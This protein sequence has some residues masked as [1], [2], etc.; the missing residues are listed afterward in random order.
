M[1]KPLV[2]VGIPVFNARA[3][4]K[5]A[6]RSVMCQSF[7]DWELLIVDDGS[8]DGVWDLLSGL[9]DPRIHCFRHARN[10]GL[11]ATLNEIA[12]AARGEFVARMDADD[13]MHPARLEAQLAAF[14]Q[15]PELSFLWSA[16]YVIG[17][18][19]ELAGRFPA[20]PG[21]LSEHVLLRRNPV[22]HPAVMARTTWMR[23][24][25]YDAGY[26]RA[27][28][29][30]LWIRTAG[31]A[32]SRCLPRP[33]LFYRLPAHPHS[34]AYRAS[35]RTDRKIIRRHGP[36]L[37]GRAHTAALVARSYLKQWCYA[38]ACACGFEPRL[39]RRR[40]LPLSQ[41]EWREAA[42]ALRLIET[43]PDSLLPYADAWL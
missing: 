4:L 3:L 28:D 32:V 37:A 40:Y 5:D 43:C 41:D 14:H 15:H 21:S 31:D 19:G 18:S 42:G 38:C 7:R 12:E 29:R 22:V 13:M 35:C 16:C 2:S 6:I 34:A 25:P 10:Q 36:A 17:P 8:T 24:N 1:P 11:A 39:V 26:H 27:E 30:E 20:Y 33:L 9:R 23:G